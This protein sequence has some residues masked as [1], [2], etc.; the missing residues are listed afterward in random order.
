MQKAIVW[1]LG[2][3]IVVGVWFLL[4]TDAKKASEPVQNVNTDVG[5]ADVVS[6]S[7]AVAPSTAGESQASVADVPATVITFTDAGFEPSQVTIK[8][9]ETVRWM[10]NSGSKVWPASAVHPTHSIYPQKSA[11]DCLGSSFDSCRGLAKGEV[12]DFTFNNAGTWKFHDHLHASK[13][14]SVTVTE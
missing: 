8:K 3:V 7:G 5:V 14:G 9:G 6:D 11:S 13:T 12:W 10:N 4:T 1:V 2:L